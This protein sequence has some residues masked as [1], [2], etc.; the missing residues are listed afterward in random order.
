MDVAPLC[1][2][3]ILQLPKDP[4]SEHFSELTAI[5]QS[6]ILLQI[7]QTDQG[8][9]EF[10]IHVADDSSKTST[11]READQ[12]SKRA[13]SFFEVRRLRDLA[14]FFNHFYRHRMPATTA[15]RFTSS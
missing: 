2:G 4:T 1:A 3:A 11:Q 14:I 9:S 15:R 8:A 7:A 13:R 6:Q 10:S 5:A 12:R